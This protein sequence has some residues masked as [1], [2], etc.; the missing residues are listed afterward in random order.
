MCTKLLSMKHVWLTAALLTQ[1]ACN[2]ASTDE[3]AGTYKGE[4]NNKFGRVEDQF[5]IIPM[6]PANTFSVRRIT[7][8]YRNV[9][10]VLDTAKETAKYVGEY[11]PDSK[12]LK[13][14]DPSKQLYFDLKEKSFTINHADTKYKKK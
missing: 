9:A 3:I 13:L 10:G 1:F 4:W 2:T 12:V 6:Q 5:E 7:A 8:H 11:L 14:E